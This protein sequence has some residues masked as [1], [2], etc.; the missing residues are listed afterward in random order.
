LKEEEEEPH[1]GTYLKKAKII[2]DR[3]AVNQFGFVS[4][5]SAPE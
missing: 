3:S 5:G 4:A 1:E 2:P